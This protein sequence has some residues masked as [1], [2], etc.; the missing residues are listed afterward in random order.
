VPIGEVVFEA[1]R[2]SGNGAHNISFAVRRGE[3]FGIAGMAGSGRSELM[4]VLF[5]SA[6]LDAGQMVICGKV[7][8][9]PSPRAAIRNRLCFVTEDRQRTGLFLPQSIA[10]NVAVANMVKTRGSIVRQTEDVRVGDDFVRRLNIRAPD[11]EVQVVNLSGGNQQKVVLAKWLNTKGEIFIFDEPTLGID[12]GSKQE[13][14]QLMVELLKQ[15][16]AI[17]MVSSDLPEII[18]MSDRVMI[19]KEG[20]KVV[21]LSGEE[22][23]EENVLAHSIGET[24]V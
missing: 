22:I 23:S 15:S 4:S 1:K 9:H 16:K 10:R 11:S 5:G 20:H 6:R 2:V 18:S 21:E 7:V 12:V 17:I 19:M 3:I 13:I 24:P 8:K 14:Y